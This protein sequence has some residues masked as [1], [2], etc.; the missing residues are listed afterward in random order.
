MKLG[1][2]WRAANDRHMLELKSLGGVRGQQAHTI[3]LDGRKLDLSFRLHKIIEV[4]EKFG[5]APSFGNR[6][7]LPR[8]HK[9]QERVT[10]ADRSR[11]KCRI[12]MFTASPA[13]TPSFS[14]SRRALSTLSSTAAPPASFPNTVRRSSSSRRTALIAAR[15]SIGS[16]P[17]CGSA[18]TRNRLAAVVRR[19]SR[20]QASHHVANL[21][22]VEHVQ[23]FDGEWNAPL[24]KF[25][26]Q[27]IAMVVLAIEHGKIAPLAALLLPLLLDPAGEV[28]GLDFFIPPG[29]NFD[30]RRGRGLS[31]LLRLLL[32]QRFQRRPLV[33]N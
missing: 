8:F 18:A 4:V 17:N 3:F 22:R 19:H 28:G 1:T 9:L 7:L 6:F 5:G 15:N 26:D 27:L 25:M 31:F 12:T 13:R 21:R 24:G 32:A 33:G 20:A 30:R 29:N 10:K 23:S 14:T 2:A 11:P 16:M